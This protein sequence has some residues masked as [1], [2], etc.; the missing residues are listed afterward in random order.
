M[1]GAEVSGI[2][3][4]PGCTCPAGGWWAVV[5]PPPCPVH[6]PYGQVAAPLDLRIL[7]TSADIETAVR[8]ERERALLAQ[9]AATLLADPSANRTPA[10]A[11]ADA[12]AILAEIDGGKP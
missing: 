8:A 12:R 11:V 2:D 7:P 9:M 6:S 5:P 10:Q 3:P 1:G 4:I